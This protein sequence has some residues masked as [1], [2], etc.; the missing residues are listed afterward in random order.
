MMEKTGNITDLVGLACVLAARNGA[1]RKITARIR[2]DT[3][4]KNEGMMGQQCCC[5]IT[6]NYRMAIGLPGE[7]VA[8]L[9]R[10]GAK[11]KANS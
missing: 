1:N 11:L 10:S 5:P 4:G 7:P 2:A 9:R 6:R 8:P 3:D